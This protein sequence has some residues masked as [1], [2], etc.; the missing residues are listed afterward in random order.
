MYILL[1]LV[2]T[3]FAAIY[4]YYKQ[5]FTYWKNRSLPYLTPSI[6]FG[7]LNKPWSI[8][9]VDQLT[10]HY[11]IFKERGEKHAGFFLMTDPVYVPIHP[12]LVKN[13]MIKDFHHFTDRGL[14]VN[15]EAQPIIG[16]LFFS[17]GQ[18]WKNLRQK[19]TPT[20]TSGKMKMMFNTMINCTV[21]LHETI[22][23]IS[24]N[25]QT[26]DARDVMAKYTTDV[27]GSCAF[28]IECNSF[29][30]P[31]SD[32]RKYGKLMF[33]ENSIK[34]LKN[35]FALSFGNIAKKIGIKN[36]EPEVA[37]FFTKVAIDTYNYRIE[38]N[39]KRNDFM[40]LLIEMTDKDNN[41]DQKSNGLTMNDFVAQVILFFVAGFDTSSVTLSFT[42][43]NL[44][45]HLN[46]QAKL[47]EEIRRVLKKHNGEITYDAIQEM[48]YMEQVIN[49]TMR[50]Y[51]IAPAIG[52]VC[53]QDYKMPSTNLVI[54]K[55]T[56]VFIPN[57]GLQ[58]DPDYFPDPEKFDPERFSDENK[59]TI[60]PGTY[61][62]F[63]EGPRICIGLRF[64]MMQMK[65]C[66]AV[67]LKDY[68]F[69]MNSKTKVPLELDFGFVIAVKGGIWLN[70]K[71]IS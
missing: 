57:W 4:F 45:S 1:A 47:R 27:I 49:E 55:G 24:D 62:P 42:L 26:F 12:E 15:D 20:F 58:R 2:S 53:T 39:I 51:P 35:L 10:N 59:G 52:R 29:K 11:K 60:D 67:L 36:M 28:G 37:E 63:G 5:A 18:K 38:N 23:Q 9:L 34:A 71:K 3:I 19:L 50:L 70:V 40:Q 31:N 16:N 61:L 30:D 56:K 54:E 13:V 46:I 69:R 41:A 17:D 64:A 7:N 68:E 43:F 25:N 6:P 8:P 21:P 33:E 32:F 22:E 66:L 48:K 44:A 14:Y 65:M